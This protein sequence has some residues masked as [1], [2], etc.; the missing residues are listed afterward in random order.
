MVATGIGM[1]FEALRAATGSG[2]F[3]LLSFVWIAAVLLPMMS[4]LVRRLHD[5]GMS[6]WWALIGL[7]II[8]VVPLLYWAAFRGDPAPNRF[9]PPP[10][11]N[12]A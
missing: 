4:V 6:G 3:D 5:V 10:I 2:I 11:C 8:G 1:A 9:G 12:R 7:T